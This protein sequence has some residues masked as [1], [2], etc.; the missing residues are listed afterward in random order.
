MIKAEAVQPGP[1]P[2]HGPAGG[3]DRGYG[4]DFETP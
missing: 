1:A 2:P 3:I 4:P